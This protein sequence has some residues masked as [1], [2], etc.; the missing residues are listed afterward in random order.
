[1]SAEKALWKIAPA[2]RPAFFLLAGLLFLNSLVVQSNGVVS[3]SGFASRVGTNGL[4]VL[5]AADNVIIVVASGFYSL[6]VDRMK[7]GRLAIL[8]FA[9]AAVIYSLLYL[10]F[11]IGMPDSATYS[12]L[13]VL[14]DQQ[15]ILFPLVIWAIA[16]DIFATYQAK[17]LFPL[18]GGALAVGGMAG[19][20][21]SAAVAKVTGNN[22]ELLLF[23]VLLMALC[24]LVLIVFARRLT[25]D[26][27][28]SRARESVKTILR[29]G[30]DF[31]NAVPV[32]RYLALTMLLV[33]LGLNTLEYQLILSAVQSTATPADLQAFYG[34]FRLLRMLSLFA[35]QGL[36]S[37]WLMK[38]L[39]FRSI[40][41][42]L[43]ATMLAG[44]LMAML[45][46]GLLAVAVGEYLV[47]VIMEGADA[48]ARNAFVNMVPDERRGRVE[49]VS[50]RVLVS[51]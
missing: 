32:F 9:A 51:L 39:G 33:G 4:L 50:G 8:M 13:M 35:V 11:R 2:E 18:L 40:F 22:M 43:P 16:N 19:N 23:N 31:V 45:A 38:R 24:A 44:L 14:N 34:A 15:W 6:I 26:V 10:G 25:A 3:T 21:L 36:L 46:P 37:G 5:W 30:L 27:R 29:E 42:P 49:R 20:G 12:L 48:P 47:R 1:M 41:V 28:Q 7:R 17:R